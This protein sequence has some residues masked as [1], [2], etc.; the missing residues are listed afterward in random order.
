MKRIVSIS[1]VLVSMVLFFSC[2]GVYY[3]PAIQT[4]GPVVR[5]GLLEDKSEIAF[6]PEGP[7]V[8]ADGNGK[9]Y[10]MNKGEVWRATLVNGSPAPSVYRIQY[11]SSSKETVADAGVQ[12]ARSQNLD[13]E[14]ITS[15]DVL[16]MDKKVLVDKRR[17][18][19]LLKQKFSTQEQAEQYKQQ[20][21]ALRNAVVIS[22]PDG[23]PGGEIHLKSE[24]GKELVIQNALRISGALVNLQAVK[25]GEG[26]HYSRE[27]TRKYGGELELMIGPNG[28]LFVINVLS[29]E[30]YLEG[31]L[32][33]EM[34]PTFPLE[35]LKAQAVAAR[36]FFLYNF[37]SRYRDKPYDVTDDVYSQAFVG[38]GRSNDR[39]RKAISETQ[40]EVLV[41][42]G[43]LCT[44]P[45]SAVCGGHTENTENVWMGES[46]PYLRGVL[47][48][49]ESRDLPVSFDLSTEESVRRWVESAP[50]VNC[51]AE[52]HGTPDYAK[53]S[54]KY[55]RWQQRYSRLELENIIRNKYHDIGTLVDIVPVERG[56]SGRLIEIE[57]RGA[58]GKINV[59]KELNIRRALSSTALYSA[60]FVVD[61][62][63]DVNGFPE[64]FVFT[65]A[66][67]GHG[68]GMCQIGAAMMAEEG[69]S[70]KQILTHY[71]RGAVIDK[72]Y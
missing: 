31:V 38:A 22:R 69:K 18:L 46:L 50:K 8:I 19:V 29:L 5:V 47:D 36:T 57:I 16:N 23:D 61:K 28:K 30:S 43:S 13:V 66:G 49:P 65:G 33:G 71:Y 51:N 11:T 52:S 10:R 9:M 7:F 20:I 40:G 58:A 53:Y 56:V 17:Y 37:G 2:A 55:Y 45:Y 24:S 41:Y 60:C 34:I 26:F 35:A 44:T 48:D 25:V 64:E 12:E 32:P 4:T 59:R 54:V 27:E 39:I 42:N 68:V 6:E 67:W 21:P 62:I 70:A 1:T 14:K 72:Y 63:G 3:G 15:G